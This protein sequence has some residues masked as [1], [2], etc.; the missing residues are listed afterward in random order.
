MQATAINTR[1]IRGQ[2]MAGRHIKRG[3]GFWI[4]PSENSEKR[5]QV[6]EIEGTCTCADYTFRQIKCKHLYA[7]ELRAKREDVSAEPIS[8]Q[9]LPPR[10]TYPQ[11]WSTYHN[12]Q[13]N[14]KREFQRL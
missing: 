5:Y 6:N 4:V 12:A 10:R 14:E 9:E 3:N 1:E 13:T 2:H 8:F 7:V 11:K